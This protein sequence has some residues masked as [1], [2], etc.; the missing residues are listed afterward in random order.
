MKKNSILSVL[1]LS[2][3]LVTSANAQNSVATKDAPNT[4]I[5]NPAEH[6]PASGT[7][8]G[9]TIYGVSKVV[10]APGNNSVGG[11][12]TAAVGGQGSQLPSGR[13]ADV[14]KAQEVATQANRPPKA[15]DNLTGGVQAGT[16]PVYERMSLF[17]SYLKGM[18]ENVTPI[19]V[20]SKLLTSS[21]DLYQG[22]IMVDVSRRDENNIRA[23]ALVIRLS[24]GSHTSLFQADRGE[25][26]KVGN[27]V[28]APIILTKDSFIIGTFKKSQ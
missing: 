26:F 17:N 15:P 4:K 20:S 21:L 12:G 27:L 11:Q 25:N 9:Q 3:C 2:A 16:V 23:F 22:D 13:E 7:H 10:Q 18:I 1:I 14:K 24:D 6:N 5:L 8:Y 28:Q 19:H